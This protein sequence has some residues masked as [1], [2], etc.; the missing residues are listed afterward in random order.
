[1]PG[2]HGELALT[3]LPRGVHFLNLGNGDQLLWY[4]GEGGGHA[5]PYGLGATCA[6][7]FPMVFAVRLYYPASPLTTII[8]TVSVGLVVGYSWI[9]AT[10]IQATNATWGWDVA[11]RRFVTGQSA[12]MWHNHRG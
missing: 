8:F 10:L 5:N 7:A 4:I 1:M 11:W 2:R 12:W 9:N 3:G 6:V